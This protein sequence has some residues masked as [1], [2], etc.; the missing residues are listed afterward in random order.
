MLSTVKNF[1]SIVPS[2]W[3]IFDC[4]LKFKPLKCIMAWEPM[5]SRTTSL[6][7]NTPTILTSIFK[8]ARLLYNTVLFEIPCYSGIILNYFYNR[9]FPKLFYS[10][11]KSV[12]ASCGKT[13][14]V[15]NA[16]QMIDCS[17]IWKEDAHIKRDIK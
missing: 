8:L 3:E 7:L 6:I 13:M 5:G 16:L 4:G 2:K 1:S 9:L 15:I 17:N 11:T 14:N 10:L 12:S